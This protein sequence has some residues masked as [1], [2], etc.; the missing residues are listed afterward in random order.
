MGSDRDGK[1]KHTRLLW[2]FLRCARV[3]YRPRLRPD[4]ALG[5]FSLS[6]RTGG[7]VRQPLPGL[8]RRQSVPGPL[9]GPQEFDLRT[10]WIICKFAAE[11]APHVHT[12]LEPQL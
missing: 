3:F 5:Q 6:D 12:E 9:S 2:Y 11:P 10:G 1:A 4:G 8:S 7:G